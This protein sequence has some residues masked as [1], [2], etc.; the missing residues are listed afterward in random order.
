MCCLPEVYNENG[1]VW[2][3]NLSSD[4]KYDNESGKTKFNKWPQ[5]GYVACNR[6]SFFFWNASKNF[7]VTGK[8]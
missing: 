8:K 3:R 1:Y 4:E 5:V 2:A 7:R 6:I